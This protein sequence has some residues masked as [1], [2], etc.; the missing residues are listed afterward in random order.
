MQPENEP[1]LILVKPEPRQAQSSLMR[2]IISLTLYIILD[3]WIFKSWEGVLLLVTVIFIHEMGH[4]IAMKIFGYE[5]INMTFVPFVGAYVSGEATHF[6]RQK[7][8][9]MLLAGPIP[10]IIIG[11]GLL[12][13]Y[14]SDFNHLFYWASMTFLLLNLF[15]LL[16]ISPLDGGQFFETLFFHGNKIIQL[17][18]LYTS[19]AIVLYLVYKLKIYGFLLIAILLLTRIGSINLIYKVRKILDERNF[20]YHMNY[21]DLTDEQYWQIRNTIVMESKHAS[22][23]YTID[24]PSENE[25]RMI[26]TIKNILSPAY[27]NN[28]TKIQ[29]VAFV[30]LYLSAFGLPIIQWLYF[31]GYLG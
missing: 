1:V 16:P 17:I 5:G 20:D 28:M 24:F 2:T 11:V 22:K 21:S 6:S 30:A 8:L 29:V 12:F 27:E 25:E 3:Y 10:G 23:K 4:F 31:R 18:F 15:N 19:L 13:L 7:R 14:Q 9:I 26:P